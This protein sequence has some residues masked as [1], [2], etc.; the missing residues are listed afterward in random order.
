MNGNTF[1]FES[2][3]IKLT[4][5][6]LFV[7]ILI[8]VFKLIAFFITKS[9]AIYSDAMESIVNIISA[10]I[11]FLGSKIALKPPDEKYPY[12]YTKSEYFV[13]IIEAFFILFAS[14]SILWKVYQQFL[15]PR[16]FTNLNTGILL[17][18]VT[19]VLN[20]IPFLLYI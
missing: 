9:V 5:L 12:G 1:T 2:K 10:L 19:I 17:I 20:S 11:A 18:S 16:P 7:S 4:L 6:S 13:S 8:F 15:N 14:I 3:A